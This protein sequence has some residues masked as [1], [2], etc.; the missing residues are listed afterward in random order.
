MSGN[1]RKRENEFV[2]KVMAR[3]TGSAC[4]KACGQLPDLAD[5]SLAKLDRQLVQA[6]LEH[7]PGCRSVAVVLG[8]VQPMLPDM[9][10][11]DPGPAFMQQVLER[12]TGA[13][14]PLTRAARSGQTV[15]PLNLIERLGAWWHQQIFRP[16]FA[17]EVAYVA[18]VILVLLTTVPGAPL[19]GTV[20]QAEQVIQAGPLAMPVLGPVLI[21]GQAEIDTLFSE[22]GEAVGGQWQKVEGSWDQRLDRSAAGRQ[23]ALE[24]LDQAW[25]SGRSGEIN[26]AGYQ[27]M[28]AAKSTRAAWN[29]WW[30]DPEEINRTSPET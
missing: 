11:L 18:T 10:E 25:Q 20:N 22:L 2:R 16:R 13:E 6:H 29:Q 8:W 1:N 7:C 27:L 5:G 3:T 15:G 28:E 14:H 24:H 23:G 17:L 30:R 12:T 9:A 21:A 26:Q 4:E 19:R